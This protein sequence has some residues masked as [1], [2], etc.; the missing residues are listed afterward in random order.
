MAA[1]SSPLAATQRWI[2]ELLQVSIKAGEEEEQGEVVEGA[3]GMSEFVYTS[4]AETP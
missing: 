2:M 3:R 4:P 1:V